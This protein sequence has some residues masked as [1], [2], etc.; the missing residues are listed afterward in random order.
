MNVIVVSN[1]LTNSADEGSLTVAINLIR[2]IKALLPDTTVI[3]DQPGIKGSDLCLPMNKLMLSVRLIK[4]ILHRKEPVLHVPA[5]TRTLPAAVRMFLMSLY[6]RHGLYV[7][8]SMHYPIGRLAQWL[9]KL[10]RVKVITMSQ[11]TWQEYRDALGDQAAYIKMGVDTRRFHPVTRQE[12]AALREKYGLPQDKPIVLHVGHL[13]AGRNVGQ[14]LSLDDSLHGVLI[15]STQTASQQDQELRRQLLEKANLTLI[16]TYV[17][18]I[19]EYYQLADVYLFPVEEAGHCIDVPISA[20][21]AAASGLPVAGTP[22]G[23]L[24][25]LI[26]Q[27]GFEQIRSFEPRQLNAQLK[28]MASDGRSPRESALEYDWSA[29]AGKLLTDTIRVVKS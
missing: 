22:Y 28:A 23:E 3:A 10:S 4:L 13:N 25:Q 6:V 21:E 12:K 17:P 16:D 2:H 29:A 9:M 20:L 7:L 24:A 8:I 26:G 15:V 19:E 5:P 1:C 18:R 14:M 27:D 11:Q